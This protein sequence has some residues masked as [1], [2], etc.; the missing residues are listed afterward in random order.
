[1]AQSYTELKQRVQTCRETAVA[2][3]TLLEQ[4][5]KTKADALKDL[6]DRFGVTAEALPAEL[7]KVETEINS[8]TT[9]ITTLLEGV[10]G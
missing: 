2:Q 10:K 6:Q 7:V 9:Q 1:M 4:A 3:K 5:E 8:I